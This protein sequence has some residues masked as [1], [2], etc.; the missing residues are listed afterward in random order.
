MK[1]YFL[2][3]F[4]LFLLLFYGHFYSSFASSYLVS[5]GFD[6]YTNTADVKNKGGWN[7]G[8][9]V[10]LISGPQCFNGTGKCLRID[11][12][13]GQNSPAYNSVT[14]NISSQKANE[15]YV[16]VRAKYINPQYGNN[17]FIKFFGSRYSPVGYANFTTGMQFGGFMEGIYYGNPSKSGTILDTQAVVRYRNCFATEPGVSIDIC[18]NSRFNP[19]DN[20]WFTYEVHVKYNS[21]NKSDG[22]FEVWINGLQY[23]KATNIKNR[24]NDNSDVIDQISLGDYGVAK[25]TSSEYSL[26]LDDVVFSTYPINSTSSLPLVLLILIHLHLHPQ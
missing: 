1:K 15:L 10:S 3:A 26:F 17:K 21:D 25:S 4:S 7:I 13:Y 11:Y 24:H 8:S 18:R 19:S 14:K 2:L 5:D 22:I 6:S 9:N 12:K 20:Q 23:L 16:S